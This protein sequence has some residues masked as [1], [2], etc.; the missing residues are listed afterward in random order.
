MFADPFWFNPFN[1]C[2]FLSR[3]DG[4]EG[5]GNCGNEATQ[6]GRREPEDTRGFKREV[7]FFSGGTKR[8]MVVISIF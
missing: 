3:A 6:F 4:G 7:L 2:S 8:N 1:T 5:E